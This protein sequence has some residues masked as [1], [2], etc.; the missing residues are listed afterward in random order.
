MTLSSVLTDFST[1]RVHR[2]P[3]LVAVRQAQVK[4]QLLVRHVGRN[5]LVLDHGPNHARHLVAVHVH[6]RVGHLD[7]C[8]SG[9]YARAGL[10]ACLPPLG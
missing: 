6:N 4:V 7:A 1:Q 5:Q 10:V 3:N 8:P 9:H 2:A